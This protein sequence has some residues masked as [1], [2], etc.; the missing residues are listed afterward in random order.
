MADRETASPQCPPTE[1]DGRASQVLLAEDDAEVRRLLTQALRRDGY[2]VIAVP[3]GEDLLRVLRASEGAVPPRAL[4]D[5]IVSDV[6]M[7]GLSGLEMLAILKQGERSP[8]VILITAF[9]DAETHAK[10]A[11]L[12]AA[13]VFD[14]PFEVG[15]L[16]AAITSV[17][18]RGRELPRARLARSLDNA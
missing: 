13:F 8:P 5:L 1:L 15:E 11:R 12:G 18:R 9:G 16:R 14:K 17:V 10:A 6:R 2:D 7:P 3:T 4:P